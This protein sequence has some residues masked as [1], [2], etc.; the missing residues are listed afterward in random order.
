MHQ[1]TTAR[2]SRDVLEAVQAFHVASPESPGISVDLETTPS[3]YTVR[4]PY[5][6]PS[7]WTRRP[8]DIDGDSAPD[9]IMGPA[10]FETPKAWYIISRPQLQSFGATTGNVI[11]DLATAPTQYFF[12]LTA[13]TASSYLADWASVGD[14]NGDGLDD[15]VFNGAEAAFG[16]F[17]GFFSP[18]TGQT[19]TRLDASTSNTFR[20]Q[21]PTDLIGFSFNDFRPALIGDCTGDG[22]PDLVMGAEGRFWISAFHK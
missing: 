13:A 2:V 22:I 17:N 10:I 16:F 12:S 11:A 1:E 4:Y 6:T 5:A 9:F 3:A 15:L 7:A 21:A 18:Y 14:L 20:I 8:F 19:G